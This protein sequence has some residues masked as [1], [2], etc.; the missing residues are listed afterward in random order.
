MGFN[1]WCLDLVVREQIPTQVI[2]TNQT[3]LLSVM[4]TTM[5]DNALEQLDLMDHIC[6]GSHAANMRVAT[7]CYMH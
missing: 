6:S 5:Q 1:H 4:T 2:Q 7:S 3:K